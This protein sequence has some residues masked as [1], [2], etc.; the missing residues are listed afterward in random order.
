MKF[1]AVA[2]VAASITMSHLVVFKET[3]NS[4]PGETKW[5]KDT[6]L[7]GCVRSLK[8]GLSSRLLKK[9][10]YKGRAIELDDTASV[11]TGREAPPI[12][13]GPPRLPT[14]ARIVMKHCPGET[15][16]I[17][18]ASSLALLTL[19]SSGRCSNLSLCCYTKI[20]WAGTVIESG[21]VKIDTTLGEVGDSEFV[22]H[23]R[24]TGRKMI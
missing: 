5:K 21:L 19:M 20:P 6:V 22:I 16:L 10:R 2:A 1:P 23:L 4:I 11:C 9:T 13:N 12:P 8:R 24:S 3:T 7:R 15:F 17:K 18:P 14:T